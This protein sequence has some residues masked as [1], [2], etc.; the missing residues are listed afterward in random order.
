M[1]QP[2]IAGGDQ[3]EKSCWVEAV[4]G[5][6]TPSSFADCSARFRSF[7]CRAMRKPGLKVPLDHALPMQFQDAGGGEA[8]HQRLAHLGRIG[9]GLA[10]EDQCL[11]HR[12]D[13]QGDDDLVGDL[14]G[15]PGAVIA[16][17]G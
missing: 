15:L 12:L 17:P 8:A 13:R 1:V 5:S 10:G 2:A 14:G 11:G 9:A 3:A 7:W 6:A 4:L 16:R